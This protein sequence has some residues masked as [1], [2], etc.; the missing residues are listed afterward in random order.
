VHYHCNVFVRSNYV[1]CTHL[2][3]ITCCENMTAHT[4]THTDVVFCVTGK[5]IARLT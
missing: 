4:R 1:Q 5:G 2:R 3:G